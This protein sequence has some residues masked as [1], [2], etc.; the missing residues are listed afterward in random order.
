MLGT[1]TD[2]YGRN[3]ENER[4]GYSPL[5]RRRRNKKLINDGNQ[6]FNHQNRWLVLHGFMVWKPRSLEH[7]LAVL[8]LRKSVPS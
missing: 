2:P 4:A 7:W 8:F 3:P 1:L 5:E 6:G